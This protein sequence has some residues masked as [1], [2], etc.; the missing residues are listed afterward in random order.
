MRKLWI[1]LPLVLLLVG[2]G[3][4]P[5]LE[6]V[7]D[8]PAEPVVSTV[9][10]IQVQ[11]PKEL[12]AP[13]LQEETAGQLYLCDDYSVTLQTVTSGD[14]QKTIRNATGME[15]DALQ[16]QKMRQGDAKR[17]QFVWSAGSE[18]GTQVGRCCIIDDGA[19]HYVLTAMADE[20][21]AGELQPVWQEMFTSFCLAAEREPVNSGS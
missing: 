19:Y 14:L 13:A 10:R 11:L 17:Y 16:I 7:T 9:R 5:T 8:L 2:C 4:K 1:V 20:G 21:V 15:Q 3:E 12:S 6:T 18:S